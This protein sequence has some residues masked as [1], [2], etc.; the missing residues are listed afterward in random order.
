MRL[1]D[2]QL[3]AAAFDG[4]LEEG[5]FK[6]LQRRLGEEPELLAIYR[7]HAMLHHSLCEEFE[8]RRSLGET[9][10]SV[11]GTPRWLIV[12]LILLG[13]AALAFVAWKLTRPAV[14]GPPLAAL[15]LSKDASVTADGR[16]ITAGTELAP[17]SRIS[18]ANGWLRLNLPQKV[19]AVVEA[20]ASLVYEANR[21]VRIESG[22]AR[23]QV[24]PG[25][26][27]FTVK[28]PSGTAVA[29]SNTGFGVK[30]DEIHVFQG[31]VEV[32]VLTI[33]ELLREGEAAAI[34]AEGAGSI[35]RGMAA[36]ED[37]FPS[38]TPE[39]RVLLEDD[40][41]SG[42]METGRRPRIGASHWRLESG[43]PVIKD[44]YLEGSDFEAFFWIPS[45]AVTASRPIL[46]VTLEAVR[47]GPQPFHSQGW[48][49]ISLYQEG[50][51]V[52]FFGD[53]Y[54]PGETWSLDVKRNLIP[55]VP[56]TPLTGPRTMTLRYDRRDGAVELHEGD[57]PGDSPLVRSKLLPG[58]NLDQVRIGASAESSLGVSSLRVKAVEE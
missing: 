46:L 9:V 39:V 37:D 4:G 51:E 27:D 54:G 55:L 26:D 36:N 10:P 3:I 5:E 49:G 2:H 44:N 19:V 28:T 30:P 22:R 15:S 18:I 41:D 21:S 24:P 7:E 12:V 40:F 47:S 6:T 13:A 8:G 56:S 52:C 17:G 34:N 11:G 45:N 48:S 23:F 35:A 57:Q 29:A 33:N 32:Y 50:Y 16:T 43:A 42:T 31:R 14:A 53:S 20:P 1:S 38:L 25:V 58:L